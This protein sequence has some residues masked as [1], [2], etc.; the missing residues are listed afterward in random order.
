[1]KRT[2]K[3]LRGVRGGLIEVE[4]ISVYVCVKRQRASGGQ[5]GVKEGACHQY[6]IS[7]HI[8]D[9]CLCSQALSGMNAL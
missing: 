1:M 4:M 6:V 7:V 8:C 9:G 3:E 2:G 5:R